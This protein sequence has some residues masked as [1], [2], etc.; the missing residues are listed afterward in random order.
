ML[1][2]QASVTSNLMIK[3]SDKTDMMGG[4]SNIRTHYP[5]W[6]GGTYNFKW[7]KVTSILFYFI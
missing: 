3:W 5:M 2:G 6:Q 4:N 7:P 1:Q